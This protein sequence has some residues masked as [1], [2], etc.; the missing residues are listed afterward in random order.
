MNKRLVLKL[1]KK[2]SNN[3]LML[4]NLKEKKTL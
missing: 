4:K 1:I 3:M 2:F